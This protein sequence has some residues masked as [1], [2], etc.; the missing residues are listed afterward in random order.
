[1]QCEELN[2]EQLRKNSIFL[3]SNDREDRD[4]EFFVFIDNPDNRTEFLKEL[5]HCLCECNWTA[6]Q[7]DC[8]FAEKNNRGQLEKWLKSDGIE[9]GTL[10]NPL[11]WLKIAIE[12]YPYRLFV[13]I[14]PQNWKD[15]INHPLEQKFWENKNP[16][17]KKRICWIEK[18]EFQQVVS[19]SENI[20]KLLISKR[21]SHIKSKF[22]DHN[23]IINLYI[24]TGVDSSYM[25]PKTLPKC[26]SKIKVTSANDHDNTFADLI[27]FVDDLKNGQ[28]IFLRHGQKNNIVDVLVSTKKRYEDIIYFET[29]SGSQFQFPLLGKKD[30]KLLIGSMECIL[31]LAIFDERY[32]EWWAQS[33]RPKRKKDIL[34][35]KI[36]PIGKYKFKVGDTPFKIAED[37]CCLT[38]DF[39]ITISDE[40]NKE[41]EYIIT[42]FEKRKNSLGKIDEMMGMKRNDCIYPDLLVIH[43]GVI[44]K[45]RENNIPFDIIQAKD[46]IPYIIITSGRGY[47][48]N[49]PIGVKFL[50]FSLIEFFLMSRYPE[51]LLFLKIVMSLR[52][53]TK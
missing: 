45:L 3:L 22:L 5:H 34:A 21:L 36:F 26:F 8:S 35:T 46:K 52:E 43:Q 28:I 9:D 20:F 47:P 18:D 32:V 51:K 30:K 49:L 6:G 31:N 2:K 33:Q 50:P 48:S 44:D 17:L 7:P 42:T 16:F 40:Y 19:N 14:D 53:A 11:S 38:D 15:E 25:S 41:D 23:K 13:V 10:I 39:A 24:K 1:M 37:G 29:L 27:S 12:R 4:F